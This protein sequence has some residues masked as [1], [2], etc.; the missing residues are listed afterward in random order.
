MVGKL[1]KNQKFDDMD[2]LTEFALSSV[3]VPV[4]FDPV[5]LDHVAQ[6]MMSHGAALV[7]SGLFFMLK[8]GASF[9]FQKR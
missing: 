9:F 6:L 5:N 7:L 3:M 1:T 4:A 2:M 8:D